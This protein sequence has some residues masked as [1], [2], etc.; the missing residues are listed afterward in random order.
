MPHS[1]TLA[2]IHEEE[3]YSLALECDYAFTN[4]D[5]TNLRIVETE[6]MESEEKSRLYGPFSADVLNWMIQMTRYNGR[7]QFNAAFTLS[8]DADGREYLEY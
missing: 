3:P 2:Q 7:K 8:V 5:K 6:E 1:L 4:R